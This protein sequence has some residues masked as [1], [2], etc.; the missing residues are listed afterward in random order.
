MG[1]PTALA[2]F[3][4]M[5]WALGIGLAGVFSLLGIRRAVIGGGVAAAW[6]LFNGT[7]EKTLAQ[8]SS[9]LGPGLALVKRSS[10][11]GD[12]ALIGAARAVGP[13]AGVAAALGGG[14]GER[15]VRNG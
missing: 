8:N 15:G 9:M 14:S 6:D 2:L 1:D 7:L 4:K 5:G 3:D 10:L 12:A 11:G 13:P